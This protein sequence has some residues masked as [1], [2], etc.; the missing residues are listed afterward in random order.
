MPQLAPQFDLAIVRHANG[1]DSFRISGKA[2]H[3]RVEAGTVPTLLYGVNWYL[4]YVAHMQV[5]TNGL[6]LGSAGTVLPAP[7]QMIEKP[8]LYKWRYALNENVDGY[9]APYWG[10]KR[11]QREID[12]LAMSGTNAVLIERGTD[13]VLYQTFRDAG[14]SDEAIRQWITQPAHQNWQLMGNM[15][16]FDEP[17]SMELLKKRA[18]S[19]QKLIAMLRSLGIT[20]VLPGYY[21][22]VPAD[23]AKMHPGAHV[24][25]QG[26]WNGFTRPGWL[27]PR[28]PQFEKL[29]ESFYLHQHE[30]FGDTS[31]YD[32]EVFQE[33]G[34]AGDVPVSEAAKRVQKALERAHPGALWMLM[35]WQS[36]PTQQLLAALDTSHLLIADI[37]QGR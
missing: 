6:Q 26:E 33:G 20:P 15:C 7:E 29:S 14:Y 23:F 21:G 22:I 24:V 30:L 37:E 36:N 28:D 17:I 25:T 12:I 16:C 13:L 9:S 34:N 3:I 27:D 2:G 19:A 5:S 35:A 18:H 32:M 31:I 4:K 10:E 1:R 8:A 11:W